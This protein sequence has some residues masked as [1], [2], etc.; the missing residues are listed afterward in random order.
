MSATLFVYRD[1]REIFR[2]D[3]TTEPSAAVV[4]GRVL[5]NLDGDRWRLWSPACTVAIVGVAPPAV[6]AKFTTALRLTAEARRPFAEFRCSPQVEL[7]MP[8]DVGRPYLTMAEPGGGWVEIYLGDGVDVEAPGQ[9][10]PR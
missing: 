7:L 4:G 8:Q 9:I 2:S 10:V 1:R 3:G 5:T 6:A